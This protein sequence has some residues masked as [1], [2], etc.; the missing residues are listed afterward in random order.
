MADLILFPLFAVDVDGIITLIVIAF[1]V[2]SGLYNFLK[3][4]TQK[5]QRH[6]GRPRVQRQQQKSVQD[7]I[8]QFLREVGG[9][10]KNRE[11]PIE[12]V[13]IDE[14]P[15]RQRRPQGAQRRPQQ[16]RRPAP[17][18]RRQTQ[19]QAGRAPQQP[20]RKPGA[21]L[22]DRK[23]PG[24]VGLGGGVRQHVQEHMEDHIVAEAQKHLDHDVDKSVQQHLGKFRAGERHSPPT[25]LAGAINVRSIVQL[26]RSPAG[27]QQAIVLNEILSRPKGLR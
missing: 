2:M 13:E 20:K 3:D 5:D 27:I 12:I 17:Q 21:A 23:A 15:R 6:A 10:P 7:E 22:H 18:R 8:D 4:K 14:R 1:V 24:S 25:P 11:E 16:Q 9:K 19:I 26:L